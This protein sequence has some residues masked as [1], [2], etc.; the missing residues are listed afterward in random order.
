M[1]QEGGDL[2][3]K[4]NGV[5]RGWHSCPCGHHAVQSAS[6]WRARLQFSSRTAGGAGPSAV[7]G[8]LPGPLR[9]GGPTAV[10][11]RD[12]RGR[13]PRAGLVGSGRHWSGQGG[14]APHSALPSTPS[15]ART[16]GSGAPARSCRLSVFHPSGTIHQL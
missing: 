6:G 1:V 14:A 8:G 3:G 10:L 13:G 4:L 5:S 11:Q 2:K 12:G 7:A 9:A 15:G 16:A